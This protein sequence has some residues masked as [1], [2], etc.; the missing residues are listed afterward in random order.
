[1]RLSLT[2]GFLLIFVEQPHNYLDLEMAMKE[3]VW[4]PSGPSRS[5]Y[6]AVHRN[7]EKTP[8]SRLVS[9]LK[10]LRKTPSLTLD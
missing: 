7:E 6:E 2:E 9:R 3:P 5:R 10:I 4:L 8:Q 1:M